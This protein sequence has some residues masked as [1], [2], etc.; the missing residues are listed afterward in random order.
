MF[1]IDDALAAG[2]HDSYRLVLQES[3]TATSCEPPWT[4]TQREGRPALGAGPTSPRLRRPPSLPLC[5][6]PATMACADK[7]RIQ[8][9]FEG[10]Q[11]GAAQPSA[12]DD[13][14]Y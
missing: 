8:Q 7:P 4:T 14:A 1:Y 5:R 9:R 13:Y 11:S 2:P 6:R 10:A 12:F 3:V